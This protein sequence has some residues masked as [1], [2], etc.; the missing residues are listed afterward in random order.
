MEKELKFI[1][2]T[3]T[4]GSAIETAGIA[5]D[6]KWGKHHKEYGHW[7]EFFTNKPIELKIKYDWFV[8]V[9]NPYDRILSEYYSR[10][11]GIGDVNIDHT[12]NEMNLYLIEKINNRNN[13]S[14]SKGHYLEQF[15]YIDN[16][17]VI[18]IL[19]FENL[20]KEFY[21]LMKK[22]NIHNIM[23]KKENTKEMSKSQIKYT[24]NDFSKELIELINTVY[25]TDF[26]LFD[27]K[28][29]IPQ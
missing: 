28:K 24:T 26:V 21:E 3:K 6:I 19:K 27:Y 4:A 14:K 1:H 11:G 7:H 23:L 9:R 16:I 12:K 13:W 2:I 8:V 20:E 22:Y 15:K 5:C 10:Y 17:T 29:H 25:N 18:N